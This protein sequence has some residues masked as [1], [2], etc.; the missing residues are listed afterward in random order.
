VT[1]P[2]APKHGE[3]APLQQLAVNVAK[4][5]AA[6]NWSTRALAEHCKVSR[7]FIRRIEEQQV[8]TIFLDPLA[9]LARGLGVR[10]SSLFTERTSP[11]REDDRPIGE[12]LARNLVRFRQIR[13]WT[14]EELAHQSGVSMYLIAHVERQARTPAL[15]TVTKLARA[16]EMP[17][18]ALLEDPRGPK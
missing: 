13:A 10:P 12:V 15:T 1:Q 2:A 7:N 11:A 4:L 18:E 8:S 5:R 3:E 14:Q 9:R 17:L 6:G 16:L